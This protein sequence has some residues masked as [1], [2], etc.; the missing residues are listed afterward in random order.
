VDELVVKK[1]SEGTENKTHPS[2]ARM[3]HP[4]GGPEWSPGESLFTIHSPL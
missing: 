4:A 3:G 2:F 1:R